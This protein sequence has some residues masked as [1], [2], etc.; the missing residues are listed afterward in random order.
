MVVVTLFWGAT[1][2]IIKESLEDTSPML[3]IAT[4]FT[5]AS[6]LITPFLFKYKNH[7]NKNSVIAGLVLGVILFISF[8]TQTVGLKSTSATKSSFFTSTAVVMVP[9]LQLFISKRKPT[10]GSISGVLLVTAGITFFS[11]S[12][13]SLNEFIG[14]IGGDFNIGD[15]LTLACA[16]FFALYIVYLDGI[17]KKYNFWVLTIMQIYV[18]AVLAL[19]CAIIFSAGNIETAKFDL[20]LNLIIGILYTA[21]FA[22]FMSTILQTKY[23]KLI[24]PTKAGLIFTLEPVFAAIF[25]FFAISEKISNLGF[26]GAVLIFAG[27]ITSEILDFLLNKNGSKKS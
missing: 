14:E 8:A 27:L 20:T 6:I 2:V 7:F 10:A 24:A 26:I 4:R 22:T 25:A 9:F 17:S 12:G 19:L 16:F 5:I 23:Q 11:S 18:T 15:V 1:F 3:F 13:Q 21:I